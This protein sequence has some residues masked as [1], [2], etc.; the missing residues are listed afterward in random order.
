MSFRFFPFSKHSTSSRVV[1]SPSPR[2]IMSTWG[3]FSSILSALKVACML[4]KTVVRLGF[5]FFAFSAIFG[6]VWLE[7]LKT[8]NPS[9]SGFSFFIHL[10]VFSVVS[11]FA[12]WSSME[13][14]IPSFF[15]IVA[16]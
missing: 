11:P 3:Y 15:R 1:Y 8:E 2:T 16:T 7:Q 13:T 14:S 9:M 6:A 4:P 10:T 5:S 12:A